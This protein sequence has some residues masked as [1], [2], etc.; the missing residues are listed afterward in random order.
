MTK[1]LTPKRR[2]MKAR[3]RIR[4][5]NRR[6][7]ELASADPLDTKRIALLRHRAEQLE[8]FTGGAK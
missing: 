1:K 4:R 5:I 2:L 8:K 3:N 6:K 7:T